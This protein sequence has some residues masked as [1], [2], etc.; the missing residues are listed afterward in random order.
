[1]EDVRVRQSFHGYVRL[2]AIQLRDLGHLLSPSASVFLHVFLKYTILKI[3]NNNIKVL[4]AAGRRRRGAQDEAWSW[5][6]RLNSSPV[7]ASSVHFFFVP[8]LC[9]CKSPSNQQKY[10]VTSGMSFKRKYFPVA[11]LNYC[12]LARLNVLISTFILRFQC[13]FICY[14]NFAPFIRFICEV[15]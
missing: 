3:I 2:Q 12:G 6:C 10:H 14:I 9:S 5:D 7:A 8:F 15:S 1:M 11:I 13:Y 4:S